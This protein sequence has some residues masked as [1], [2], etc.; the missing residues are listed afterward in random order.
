MPVALNVWFVNRSPSPARR[1]R[2]FTIARASNLDILRSVNPSRF[3]V[4]DRNN[5]PFIFPT[6]RRYA[7][8]YSTSV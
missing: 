3:C 5:A 2:R 4:S 6:A 1:Q 8:M 7:S